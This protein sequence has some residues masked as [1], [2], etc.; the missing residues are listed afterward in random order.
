MKGL[1]FTVPTFCA[2]STHP[3]NQYAIIICKQLQQIRQYCINPTSVLSATSSVLCLFSFL[4][5][6]AKDMFKYTHTKSSL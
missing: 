5:Q 2:I 1:G 6:N 3:S 4:P